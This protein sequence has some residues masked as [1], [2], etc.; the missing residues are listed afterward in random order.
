MSKNECCLETESRDGEGG[1]LMPLPILV[2]SMML[3]T[4]MIILA[5]GGNLLVIISYIKDKKLH[6]AHNL[7]IFHLAITDFLLGLISMPFYAVYTALVWSWP[8][9]KVFCKIYMVCDFTLC[10]QSVLLIIIISWDRLILVKSGA[11]YY[12]KESQN[13]ARIKVAMSWTFAFLLYGP[14]IIGYDYWVGHSLVEEGDCDVEFFADFGFTLASSLIEFV[15]PFTSIA[16]INTLVYLQIR[17]RQ[18]IREGSTIKPK[19]QSKWAADNSD[20]ET[21]N[22]TNIT[23]VTTISGNNHQ[24]CT[25]GNKKNTNFNKEHKSHK[26]LKAAKALSILVIALAVCWIPYTVSTIVIAFSP[27]SIDE[28]FYEIL[29]WLLWFKASINPFLYAFNS[30]R[31]REN[32]VKIL[33]LLRYVLKIKKRVY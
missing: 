13:V 1:Q 15:V 8:F 20:K 9:G 12:M 33:P 11:Q 7:Y 32:F 23:T 6:N 31:F 28:D 16:F 5:V 4:I 27:N 2:P 18:R 26:D 14:A 29:N 19:P 3:I 25:Y 17:K 10:L 24:I 30:D 21:N 22:G